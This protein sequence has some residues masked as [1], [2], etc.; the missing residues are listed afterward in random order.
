MNFF[1]RLSNGW[2][3]T[4]SSFKVLRENKE[5]IV[6]PILSGISLILITGS[7]IVAFLAA[8]GWDIDNVSAGD[9]GSGNMVMNVALT[10]CF[11]L[12]NYFVVIF[13]NMALIH[14][15][16]MYFHGE[17]VSIRKG[18]QFSVSRIGAIFT[19]SIFAA[20]VGTILRMLQE[21]LGIVGKIITGLIGIVWSVTTFFVVPVIAYENV[22][23]IDAFKRSANLMRKQW[24]ESLVANFSFALVQFIGVFVVAMALFF[25]GGI[26]HV[27]L[28]VAL[29]ILG[30][31]VVMA[32]ISASQTI[33][34]SAVYHNINGDPVKNFNENFANNLFN[35][36]N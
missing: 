5:L 21:N 19:W 17:P 12:I 7:F 28:G 31:F 36:K 25:L 3:L 11:Y 23:P 6:F 4:K 1:T 13:F 32:I 33:F 22:G 18:L 15:T 14:C 20:T 35:E 34:I 2:E 8:Y 24:G 26:I 27:F 16:R 29:A 30:A 9:N 10:F